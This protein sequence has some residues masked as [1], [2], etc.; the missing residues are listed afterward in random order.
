[1]SDK[2]GDFAFDLVR[3]FKV[4][5]VVS[6]LLALLAAGYIT[7]LFWANPK[8]L[9]DAGQYALVQPMVETLIGTA[10]DVS[11]FVVTAVLALAAV[12]LALEWSGKVQIAEKPQLQ[13]QLAGLVLPAVG[14]LLTITSSFLI[15]I[16]VGYGSFDWSAPYLAQA[17]PAI[18]F[19][20]FMM[21]SQLSLL[22]F[23]SFDVVRGMMAGSVL[24]LEHSPSIPPHSTEDRSKEEDGTDKTPSAPATG[25]TQP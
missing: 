20:V 25:P 17:I 18:G 22:F 3:R 7:G 5:L 10:F 13:A 11:T 4:R 1:M 8:H 6:V 21:V 24:V 16:W 19:L 23:G 9:S 2:V 14:S 12:A 15:R